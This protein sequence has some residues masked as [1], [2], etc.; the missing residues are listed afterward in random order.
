MLALVTGASKGIG[1]AIALELAKNNFDVAI[2]FNRSEEPAK[3]LCAE[4]KNLGVKAEIFK[5]DVSDYNQVAEMF[6]N[7]KSV[8]GEAVSILVNNA[9][10][11][12]DTLL[13]RM[14]PEDWQTVINTNLN[15]AFYCTREA[16]RDMA[17]ARYGRIINIASVVGLIGNAGQA[18]YAASKAGIIGLTKSIAR[19]YAERGITANAI[20]PGFIDTDMTEGLKPEA[21]EGILKS[22]PIGKIGSPED[23]ARAAAFFASEANSYI[24]GQVLAVDGGMTMY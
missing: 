18:N 17:K 6:K 2:N 9:G 8:M 1:R 10:V 3:N 23:V 13:M 15:A 14:K 7:V 22:I 5:A 16:I 4:I 24:T 11:T 20:A 21:K 19:E 12:R